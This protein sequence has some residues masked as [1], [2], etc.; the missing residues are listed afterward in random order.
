M[1]DGCDVNCSF[2]SLVFNDFESSRS[3]G[4]VCP[5]SPI[6]NIPPPDYQS[7]PLALERKAES[8]AVS[9][10][11]LEKRRKIIYQDLPQLNSSFSL[12]NDSLD[13]LPT[14]SSLAFND[15]QMDT[16]DCPTPLQLTPA[17]TQCSSQQSNASLLGYCC[18]ECR[19]LARLNLLEVESCQKNF[20]ARTHLEQRQFLLDTLSVTASKGSNSLEHNFTLAGKHLCKTAFLKVLAISEKRMRTITS[21]YTEGATISRARLNLQ[22]NNSM[23]YSTSIAWME[24]YFNRIGD[25]MPHLQQ[26]HLPHFLSKKMVYELMVQDLIDQGMCK[27]QIISSS[28]FYAIWREEF[29]NC[30]IPKVRLH[31]V[32]LL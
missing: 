1:D 16:D 14:E 15:F 6:S 13:E 10:S 32:S 11:P 26:I 7:T 21:L 9:E 30:V 31:Y 27:E 19:C 25:K 4:I 23:K 18:C 20:H 22:R 24:H 28:H 2:S 8:S 17:D 12:Y 29:R 3:S 5:D